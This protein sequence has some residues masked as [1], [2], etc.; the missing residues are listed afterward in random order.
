VRIKK[1][2][3]IKHDDDYTLLG[4]SAIVYWKGLEIKIRPMGGERNER[5]E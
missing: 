2:S 5:K 1:S 3:M 4:S